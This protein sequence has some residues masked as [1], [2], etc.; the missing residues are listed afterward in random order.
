MRREDQ[1]SAVEALGF[2]RRQAG[3]LVTVVLTSG[4]CVPRQYAQHAGIALGHTTRD[5]FARLVTRH[6]ATAYPCWQ[7]SARVY[8]VHNKGLYRAVGE[9]DNRHRRPTTVGR[10]IE[11]LMV[12]DAVLADPATRW[13]ATE[14]EKLAHF[15][16][17]RNLDATDLPSVAFGPQQ[18]TVRYFPHKL[19]IGV[20]ADGDRTVFLY[21]ATESTGREFA[22]FLEAHRR[23]LQRLHRWTIR[24]C[25]PAP[26]A[27]ARAAHERV[28]ADAVASPLRP[29]L[30]D[31]F[32]W[33]CEAR[34]RTETGAPACPAAD[35]SRYQLARRAF[36]APRFY[37]AYRRWKREGESL[38]N[39]CRSPLLHDAWQRGDAHLE[40][41][42]LPHQ[43]LHLAPVVATA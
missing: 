42:D 13:L 9:P 12:L 31:E 26:L 28:A 16:Q 18:E 30:L 14:S 36:G 15:R 6:L 4:V 24:L 10:A 17:A 21:L 7:G 39:E 8:H 32:R 41:H 43:Y 20:L 37:A 3:F 34:R 40:I 38:F 33:F 2:T 22:A 23:L 19:P 29:A 35:Q 25:L 11:R 5:F 27:T 1:L